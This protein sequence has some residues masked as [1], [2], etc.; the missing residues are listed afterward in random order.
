M[1]ALSRWRLACLDRN[2]DADPMG[3]CGVDLREAKGVEDVV[4]WW[5]VA[6]VNAAQASPWS[7]DV[8]LATGQ[9]SRLAAWHY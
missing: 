6:P 9:Q 7:L 2:A 3:V 8:P 1:E 4:E 5:E